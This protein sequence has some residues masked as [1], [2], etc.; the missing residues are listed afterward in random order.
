MFSAALP[1]KNAVMPIVRAAMP[2]KRAAMPIVRAAMPIKRA[3]MPMAIYKLYRYAQGA[4]FFI[5]L[6]KLV[7]CARK[8]VVFLPKVRSYADDVLLRSAQLCR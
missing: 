2:I 6:I 7:C 4:S 3:A 1:I 5:K 8:M